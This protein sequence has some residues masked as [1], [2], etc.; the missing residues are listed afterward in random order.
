MLLM[1]KKN[2]QTSN[3]SPNYITTNHYAKVQGKRTCKENV[4]TAFCT[5]RPWTMSVY[6]HL[7]YYLVSQML[8]LMEQN[9][10]NCSAMW[11][12]VEKI[13]M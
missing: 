5:N 7:G 2:I 8:T 9:G 13:N 6:Q 10:R 3:C 11:R 4:P 1:F 12:N